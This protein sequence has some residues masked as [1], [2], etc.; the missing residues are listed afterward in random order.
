[1]GTTDETFRGQIT[2]YPNIWGWL[3]KPAIQFS[4]SAHVIMKL[5]SF[6]I[7]PHL[8]FFVIFPQTFSSVELNFKEWTLNEHKYYFFCFYSWNLIIYILSNTR[9]NPIYYGATECIIT[10]ITHINKCQ[11]ICIS[12]N[13]NYEI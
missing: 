4:L 2:L 12:R 8:L 7:P 9:V 13:V 1:M 11:L 5:S 3:T 6:M 10:A